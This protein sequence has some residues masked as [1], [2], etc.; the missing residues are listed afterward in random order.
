MVIK[1]KFSNDGSS[2]YYFRYDTRKAWLNSTEG[3]KAGSAILIRR[4]KILCI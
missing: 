1:H 2:V 3:H 4:V